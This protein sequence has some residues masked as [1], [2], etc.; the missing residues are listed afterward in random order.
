MLNVTL[1]FT[2]L[3]C[4]FDVVNLQTPIPQSSPQIK[5]NTGPSKGPGGPF[6]VLLRPGSSWYS[7][8]NA[9]RLTLQATDGNLVLQV[10]DDSTIGFQP[11]TGGPAPALD[12]SRLNWSPV[13]SPHIQGR[14]VT[15][16]A[17]QLDGNLVAYAGSTA[18]F[19]TNTNLPP[20]TSDAQ[21][22]TLFLQDDGNL[23]IYTVGPVARFATNTSA[24]EAPGKNG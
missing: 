16:V 21:R 12:P 23:V 3:Q 5:N 8:G 13:W 15:E 22:P 24:L 20:G 1:Q 7:P 17:F 14:G 6:S 4:P 10:V 18:V 9:F 11:T 2:D 19:A